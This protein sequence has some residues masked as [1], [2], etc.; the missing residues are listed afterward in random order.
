MSSESFDDFRADYDNALRQYLTGRGEEWLTV[1]HELGRRALAEGI[2]ILDI[3]ENH[4]RITTELEPVGARQEAALRFLLQTLAAL[5]I[6]T[7]G[8]LDS[9][10]RYAQ[11]AV[12]YDEART[13]S[14]AFQR[15]MLGA[16]TLPRGFAVRYEPAETPL[17]IGGDWY[18][19]AAL[20]DG[21]I[22]VVVGDCVG[23]G[24][25]AAVVM[26]QLRSSAR[27]LL[28]TGAGPGLMLDQLDVVAAQIPGAACTTVLAAALDPAAGILNYSSAGHL[29]GLLAAPGADVEWL[30]ERAKALPLAS[31][32]CAPRPEATAMVPAGTV[33]V[34]FT[35]GL[36]ER[37][38][39]AIDEGIDEVAAL[40]SDSRIR[41][42]EEIADII[43][44]AR[45]PDA[46]YDDDVALVVY[47][48]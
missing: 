2:S 12:R 9:T 45:R 11:L 29:P 42:V 10:R 37:R 20:P 23:R 21:R 32:P 26:G 31:F 35:D 19:V 14:L 7:R 25:D 41:D 47:R 6:A 22:G 15:A 16:P 4:Y 40:L 3:T 44:A 27:A 43:L 38:A 1:G 46:G 33:V 48:H 36:V 24:L 18:D 17:E 39:T 34:F 28:S 8:F 30:H 13:A 5:D